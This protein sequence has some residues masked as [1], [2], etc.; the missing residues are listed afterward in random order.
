MVGAIDQ[1]F[2][3]LGRIGK[4]Q[5]SGKSCVTEEFDGSVHRGLADALIQGLNMLIEFLKSMVSG[6]FKEGTGYEFSLRCDVKAL[7][8]H[9]GEELVQPLIDLF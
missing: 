6:E 2:V 3:K 4:M 7:A 9:K 5:F 8:A 1:V